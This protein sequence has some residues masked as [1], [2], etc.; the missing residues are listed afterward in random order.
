MC[1]ALGQLKQSPLLGGRAGV[2]VMGGERSTGPRTCRCGNRLP[3]SVKER[4]TG[5]AQMCELV[6]QAQLLFYFFIRCLPSCLIFRDSTI[7]A[8]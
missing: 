8:S 7:S 4:M 5:R 3:P 1:G 2:I 6:S